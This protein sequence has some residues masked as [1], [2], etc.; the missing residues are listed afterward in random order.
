M[1]LSTEI[2]KS[3][4]ATRAWNLVF[5]TLNDNLS[6]PHTSGKWLYSSYPEDKID[7][8]SYPLIVIPPVEIGQTN[9]TMGTARTVNVPISFTVEIYSNKSD[10]L[11]TVT[12]DVID[13]LDK[14]YSTTRTG[15]LFILGQDASTNDTFWTG[16]IRV[17][18]KGLRFNGEFD[19]ECAGT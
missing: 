15:N 6:N 1:A 8:D 19:Y 11:D 12:D 18:F 5:K 3:A 2:T 16:E 4:I 9:L 13:E 17:H 10:T 14:H 7:E